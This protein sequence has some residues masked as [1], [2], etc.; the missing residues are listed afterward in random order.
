M[1]FVRHPDDERRPAQDDKCTRPAVGT[2]EDGVRVCKECAT[3]M[4]REGF[5]V[6]YDGATP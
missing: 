5:R 4:E 3:D 1:V 6:D 2:Y